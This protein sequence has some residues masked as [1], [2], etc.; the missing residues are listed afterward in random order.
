M[1]IKVLMS[2]SFAP[3]PLV[4]VTFTLNFARLGQTLE[5]ISHQTL[6]S[7][8][9]IFQTVKSTF[10]S[11]FIPSIFQNLLGH[12][13]HTATVM[14]LLNQAF[15]FI[16]FL[17]PPMR[18]SHPADLILAH[19]EGERSSSPI[20]EHSS[21]IGPTSANASISSISP[22]HL[23]DN[24]HFIPPSLLPASLLPSPCSSSRPFKGN[25]LSGHFQLRACEALIDE[26]VSNDAIF[27]NDQCE[28]QLKD[29][30]FW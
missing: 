23:S 21:F 3:K 7:A 25:F 10:F 13:C 9:P 12:E 17:R 4:R 2:R 30:Y 1:L 14:C 22:H 20:S 11:S 18:C 5:D 27:P 16:S 19:K 26:I 6:P 24:S 28:R 8:T 15:L 29:H